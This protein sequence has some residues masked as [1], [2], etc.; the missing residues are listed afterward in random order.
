[1]MVRQ[2][3]IR[4]AQ[5]SSFMEVD[6]VPRGVLSLELQPMKVGKKILQLD[7]EV[8]NRLNRL[9]ACSHRCYQWKKGTPNR[10]L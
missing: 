3:C 4:G 7:N 8:S 1:M 5:Q 2:M 6:T 10:E 9:Y